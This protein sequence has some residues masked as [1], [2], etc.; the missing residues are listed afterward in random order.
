[1]QILELGEVQLYREFHGILQE[2]FKVAIKLIKVTLHIMYCIA[3][4]Q[5]HGGEGIVGLQG[6]RCILYLPRPHTNAAF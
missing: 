4:V 2:I 3:C 6:R 1:M 5:A